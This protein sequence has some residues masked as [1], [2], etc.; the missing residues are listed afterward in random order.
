MHV[1]REGSD[2]K[3]SHVRFKLNN[4]SKGTSTYAWKGRNLE[5]QQTITIIKLMDVNMVLS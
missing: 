3:R 1:T 2:Q 4:G 5:T